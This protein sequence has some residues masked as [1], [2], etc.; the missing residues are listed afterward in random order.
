MGN[1]DNQIDPSELIKKAQGGDKA[2]FEKLY[3][4]YYTPVYRY[5]YLRVKEKNE[6]SSIAQDVFIK[7]YQSLDSYK[8]EKASPLPYF[9]TIAR[10]TIIDYWRKNRHLVSF[11]K[12][13]MML[14]VP[15]KA[16]GPEELAKKKEIS[17]LLYF[18]MNKLNHNEREAITMRYFNDV[19]N[20][21]I[22]KYMGKS[23]EAVR[24]LQSRGIKAL[25][26][27]LT[28]LHINE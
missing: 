14:Q 24:Q 3:S 18:G 16:D 12:E 8:T 25:R 9:F 1:G 27:I 7:V 10:N 13:D 2:A 26:K 5:I 22:A 19:P 28:D 23:E 17:A 15:D 6:V 4:M 11:G 20:K 21:E